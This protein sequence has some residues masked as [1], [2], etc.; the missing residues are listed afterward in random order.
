MAPSSMVFQALG[1]LATVTVTEPEAL[2]AAMAVVA[3]EIAACDRACSRFRG[4]SELSRL[5]T[6]GGRAIEVSARLLDE[7]AVA[8]RAAR[9]T[10][11]AVDPTI[12]RALV[13]LGYDRDFPLVAADRRPAPITFTPVPGWQ[14]LHL[15]HARGRAQIPTGVVVDLGATAKARCADL[16]APAAAAAAGCGVLVS[17]GGDLAVAG[18]APAGGWRV[19]VTDD[20]RAGAGAP[21]QRIEILTGGLAT[22]GVTVRAWR[23][24]GT[25][26][27]HVIDPRTGAPAPV[28]WRTVSVAAATCTDANIASTAAIVLGAAAPA[29]LEERRLPARLVAPDGAV[30]RVAGWPPEAA[31][32]VEAGSPEEAGS[33]EQAV[34]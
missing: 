16:A 27:H 8:V 22:S 11:G 28:V 34:A 2:P 1:T 13:T 10:D 24:A 18:P 32:P 21:G 19:H 14:C 12:G 29:W 25:D 6:A 26:L 33:A 23:R 31:S 15:D 17:L 4:D 7:L 30:T 5:N 20:A 9:I 3:A